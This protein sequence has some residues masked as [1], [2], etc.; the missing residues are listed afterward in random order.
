M[1]PTWHQQG[2][3][4]APTWYQNGTKTNPTCEAKRT[5]S[6]NKRNTH[7][8]L[9][10]G[11]SA[12]SRPWRNIPRRFKAIQRPFL[13]ML[14]NARPVRNIS[15]HSELFQVIPIYSW[16]SWECLAFLSIPRHSKAI[17]QVVPGYACQCPAG[18]KHQL[19]S[20]C[21]CRS[22]ATVVLKRIAKRRYREV[23]P[24]L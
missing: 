12:N 4:M 24:R 15:Q 19:G 2:T 17:S 11:M 5:H 13:G 9:F 6:G 3:K 21:Q 1:E 18:A 7:P 23:T 14:A 8:K 16:Y 20:P 10:L 22:I